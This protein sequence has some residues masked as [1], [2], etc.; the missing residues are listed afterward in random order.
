MKCVAPAIRKPSPTEWD[1]S[2]L[3]NGRR[4]YLDSGMSFEE[5]VARLLGETTVIRSTICPYESP[6]SDEPKQARKA[7]QIIFLI[8][9]GHETCDLLYNAPDGLRGRY[10][11]SPDHGSAATRHLINTLAPTLAAFAERTPPAATGKAAPMTIDDIRASLNAPSAKVWPWEG[12]QRERLLIEHQ[13]MVPRWRE[14][15]AHAQV[16]KRMWRRNPSGPE[17]EIKGALIGPDRTEYIPEGKRSRS[18]QIFEF[19]FT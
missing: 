3:P 2:Q 11:Q 4:T 13:L 12:E 15:E 9:G 6:A 14:S 16:N 8:Q 17:L 7:R 18:C 19:G 10:W 5:M 1:T